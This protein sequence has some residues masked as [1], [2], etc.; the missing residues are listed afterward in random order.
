MYEA[1]HITS[2]NDGAEVL[3][4]IEPGNHQKVYGHLYRFSRKSVIHIFGNDP[5]TCSSTNEARMIRRNLY[6]HGVS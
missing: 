5:V 1:S 4:I 6:N 3:A 2:F